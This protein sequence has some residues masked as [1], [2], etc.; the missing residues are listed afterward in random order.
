[1][2]ELFGVSDKIIVEFWHLW[3]LGGL[4]FLGGLQVWSILKPTEKASE[5]AQ[6][7]EQVSQD[8]RHIR[9]CTDMLRTQVKELDGRLD[10]HHT[11]LTILETRVGK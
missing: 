4:I 10:D 5:S 9:E 7:R 6:W 1:M 3:I 2:E 8:L 11:R